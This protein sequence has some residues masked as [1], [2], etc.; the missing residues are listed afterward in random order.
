MF[1]RLLTGLLLL[2]L[3]HASSFAAQHIDLYAYHSAPPF[4]V[5]PDTGTG[6][7]SDFV[8]ALQSFIG[9]EYQLQLKQV[10]RPVLNERLA[11]GLP[12]IVLWTH[13]SWYGSDAK[14]YLWAAPLF[15]DRDVLVGLTSDPR[16]PFPE[17]GYVLGAI[18]GYS[19]P[20]L[21][22]KVAAEKI[23]R[24]DASSD[25]ENLLKLLDHQVDAVMITRSSFLYYAKQ[26]QF[27]GKYRVVGQPYDSYHRQILLTA[28]YQQF[29]PVLTQAL[30]QLEKS[31]VWQDRLELYGLKVD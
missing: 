2:C 14:M 6:L 12:T 28:H 27:V 9:A 21:N 25:K 8:K 18:T 23:K 1:A 13:P 20:G 15:G 24:M 19:Y 31:Q 22:E 10:A 16:R 3:T 7:N 30:I 26:P 17:S 11:Q 4:L 29:L 5:N